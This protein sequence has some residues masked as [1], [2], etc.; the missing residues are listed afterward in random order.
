MQAEEMESTEIESTEPIE[1][2]DMD[3]EGDL[4]AGDVDVDDDSGE[5]SPEEQAEYEKAMAEARGESLEEEEDDEYDDSTDDD[6]EDLEEDA[7]PKQSEQDSDKKIYKLKVNGK[8]IE[9]DASDENKV[10]QAIQKGLGADHKMYQAS[11]MQKQAKGLIEALKEDP[12]SV[13]EH[14]S[15]GVNFKEFAEK[16][17]WE[18]HVEPQMLTE[19]QRQAR[20]QQRELERYR[21]ME[22]KQKEMAKRQKEEQLKAQFRQEWSKKF[23][24]AMTEHKIP[25]SDWSVRRMAQYMTAARKKGFKDVEPKHVAQY[26]KQDWLN[27]QKELLN[28]LEGDQLQEYLGK[29][30]LEK[31]R[32]AN[33]A[34]YKEKQKTQRKRMK[35]ISGGSSDRSKT[36]SSVD[37][38]QEAIRR[39]G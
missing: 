6:E 39:G 37:E 21:K 30:V 8:E 34:K 13:L 15:I 24:E 10:K 4:E 17:L 7:D 25:K 29:D 35:A 20:E 28:G 23:T 12:A 22:Q 16:W 27:A 2:V 32:Q 1:N 38:L 3:V 14:P 11:Q 18:N 26:V 19:E 9:F 33:L 36:F 31:A 5:L